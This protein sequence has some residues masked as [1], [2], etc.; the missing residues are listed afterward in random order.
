MDITTPRPLRP[1]DPPDGAAGPYA[2]SPPDRGAGSPDDLL[3]QLAASDPGLAPVIAD[4]LA[5]DLER[6]LDEVL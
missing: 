5:D 6:Q 4:Q 1:D 3:A 2:G